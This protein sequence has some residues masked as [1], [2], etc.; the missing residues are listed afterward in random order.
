L[1]KNAA[2]QPEDQVVDEVLLTACECF[3][4]LSPLDLADGPHFPGDLVGV[5][6]PLLLF[7]QGVAI[8]PES[9]S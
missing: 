3:E 2:K 7:V 5:L 1:I 4:D 6:Q 8:A 9:V